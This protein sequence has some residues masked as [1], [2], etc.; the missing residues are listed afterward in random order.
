MKLVKPS[1]E[2]LSPIDKT[3]IYKMIER[4]ARTCYK[5][6]DKI[7]ED[8]S[9]AEKLI[10]NIIS[11]KHEAMLEFADIVVKFVGP[12]GFSHE[13]VRHRLVSFAQ[14]STRYCNYSLDKFSNQVT[15]AEPE[16]FTTEELIEKYGEGAANIIRQLWEDSLN[17]SEMTYLRMLNLGVPPQLARD[18][19][20]IGLK[21]EIVAKANIREWRHIARLRTDTPAH[22]IMHELMRPVLEVFREEIPILFNDVGMVWG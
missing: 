14:E 2:I 7:S 6:E 18:I 22:P 3:F 4:A 8:T 17:H 16:Y 13:L 21:T 11:R 1:W 9:S 19:L 5:S 12:R 20:P 15:M 10:L